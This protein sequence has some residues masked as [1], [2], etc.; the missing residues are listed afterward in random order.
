MSEPKLR[1]ATQE[2]AKAIA[3]V[4]MAAR[5]EA[6]PD[7]PPLH[8]YEETV[9]FYETIVPQEYTL[10]VATDSDAVIGFIAYSKDW[11]SQ[12]H[13]MPGQWN[14]GLGTALL[15]VAKAQSDHLQ[16]WTFQAN[17]RARA[18]YKKHGFTEVELTDGSRNEEKTPDVRMMWQRSS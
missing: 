5:A 17:E 1:T 15:N 12:L 14:K 7:L 11:V 8:S 9:D 2:D 13:I 4:H 16:L 3:K 18:F 6:M 10:H